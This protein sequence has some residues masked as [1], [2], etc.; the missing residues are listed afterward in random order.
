MLTTC[1]RSGWRLSTVSS[2]TSLQ[3]PCSPCG[4]LTYSRRWYLTTSE[5]NMSWISSLRWSKRTGSTNSFHW[6]ELKKLAE[7]QEFE[8]LDSLSSLI[9]M[10][11]MPDHR[12]LFFRYEREFLPKKLA[13]WSVSSNLARL[14]WNQER[15]AKS[16]Q[17]ANALKR[18]NRERKYNPFE[19]WQQC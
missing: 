18:K 1:S 3:A 10:S 13:F 19:C 4:L 15:G 5:A 12:A 17:K 14:R 16:S 9:S 6:P 2:C 8:A 7:R 11:Q